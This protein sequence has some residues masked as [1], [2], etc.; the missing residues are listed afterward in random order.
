MF[1]EIRNKRSF[2]CVG[3]DPDPQK[4]PGSVFETDDPVFEFNKKIADATASFAVAYKPN[5][6]FYEALGATGWWSLEKTI[7]YIRK[8]YPEQLL[9][10]DAKRGDTGNSSERYAR[11]F[12]DNLGFDAVT[13]SPYMGMDSVKPFLSYKDKWAVV[14]ALTSNSGAWDFQVDVEDKSVYPL[15]EKVL[16]KTSAWGDIDNMMFVVGATREDM[17]YRVRRIVPDH[18]LLVPGVGAQGGSLENIARSGMNSR[19]GLLVNCSRSII[20]SSG[21]EDFDSAAGK[22]AGEIQQLME[23]LLRE[24]ELL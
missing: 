14:L 15:Y 10:A 17:F 22:K 7:E 19:C 9:I 23:M 2:L 24:K 18:F 1:K 16:A 5:I 13:V 11:A 20:Y 21:G 8:K 6:A 4:L 12:F 3:L